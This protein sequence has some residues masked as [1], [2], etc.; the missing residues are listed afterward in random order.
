MIM[1]ERSEQQLYLESTGQNLQERRRLAVDQW[2]K[3]KREILDYGPGEVRDNQGN[4]LYSYD[5][6]R[7]LIIE[8]KHV[9]DDCENPWVKATVETVFKKWKAENSKTIN[10]KV[11]IR[12]YG[13]GIDARL[14]L[15]K[16][17]GEGK[18]ELHIIELNE[19]VLEDANNWK[20]MTEAASISTGSPGT[21]PDVSIKIYE[22]DAIEVTRQM[23]ERKEEFDMILSDTFPLTEAEKGGKNDIIDLETLK[24]CLALGGIFSFFSWFP[25]SS[26]IA[27]QIAIVDKHFSAFAVDDKEV[28]V[29][30]PLE[31]KYLQGPKGPIRKLPVI[32]CSNPRLQAAA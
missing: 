9:M 16:L 18:G 4:I 30:P 7:R 12:G 24:K 5:A 1:T 20:E 25:G 31:Y 6:G 2:R 17:I 28:N 26:G 11:L 3:A 15:Q 23:A 10:P 22:G 8:E 19:Q 14:I 21:I 29:F 27:E 13:L 32:V